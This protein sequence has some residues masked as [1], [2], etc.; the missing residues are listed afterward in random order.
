[1]RGSSYTFWFDLFSNH[2]LAIIFYH[3]S[4]T[5]VSFSSRHQTVVTRYFHGG[6][7]CFY[8]VDIEQAIGPIMILFDEQPDQP[9]SLNLVAEYI[10]VNC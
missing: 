2:F 8:H 5:E 9:K 10:T 4:E 7:G 3:V 6:K 1:M